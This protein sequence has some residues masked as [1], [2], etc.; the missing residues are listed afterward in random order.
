MPIVYGPE[1]QRVRFEGSW[2]VV[3]ERIIKKGIGKGRERKGEKKKK[4]AG[5]GRK[6]IGGELDY[7]INGIH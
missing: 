5:K 2:P 7:P 3:L 1:M 4:E 6:R